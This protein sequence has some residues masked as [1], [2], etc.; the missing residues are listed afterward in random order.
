MKEEFL[1]FVWKNR[2]FDQEKFVTTDGNPI[3]VINPGDY[4]RDSGPDFFNA[5]LLIG[6]TLWAGNVEIHIKSSSWDMH[7]HHSDRSYDNVILHVVNE[8]NC[9]A[10]TS[11][12]LKIE[13]AVMNWDIRLY[14]K[15]Q[16]YLDAPGTI[17][18]QADLP[19]VDYFHI[20]HWI[21]S[22]AAERLELKAQKIR[23]LLKEL[24]NDWE[25]TLYRLLTRYWGM[26]V[27]AEPFFILATRL[28]L[29]IIKKHSDNLVQVEALLFG[30]AGMLE[31]GLFRDA[32]E[33]EY[34]RLL[35]REYRVLARKYSLKPVDEWMWKY[36]RMRPSNF[37]TVRISQLAALLTSREHLFASI[38]EA[39]SIDSLSE[40]FCAPAS[41]YWNSHYKF[42]MVTSSPSVKRVGQGLISALIINCVVPL[43]F[44]YG[45]E[46]SNQ[47]YCDRALKISEDIPPE[48][49]RVTREWEAA[50]IIPLSA[51]ESQGLIGLSSTM[52]KIRS[53]LN[54][55]IGSKLIS[56]GK[57]SDPRSKMVMEGP[58]NS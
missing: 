36:H 54:C 40:I 38:R 58:A 28:P 9:D 8:Y 2:Q 22:V 30:Q 47:L 18:C 32:P 20:R 45:R 35:C 44:L 5:R 24:R 19:L 10:F 16:A 51:F 43:I 33:D 29:K 52:C 42:G 39:D 56:L 57:D 34:Y 25:E 4:N 41:P 15:Y 1:H 21:T 3:E 48:R 31:E 6:D 27:N 53:C 13:T 55:Q 49:N 26:N 11:S 46:L 7:G 23:T 17:A 14:E 50:G 37:P 12:G